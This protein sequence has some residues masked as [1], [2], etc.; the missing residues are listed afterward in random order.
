MSGSLIVTTKV[1]I[2]G[3]GDEINFSEIATMTVPVTWLGGYTIVKTATTKAIQLFDLQNDDGDN[4]L[5]DMDEMYGLYI[6]AEVGIIYVLVDATGVVTFDEDQNGIP[7]NVADF[8]LNVGEACWI[9]INPLG[10]IGLKIDAN[11]V[12]A[13]FSWVIVAKA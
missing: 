8:V 13:A 11:I 7:G 6:K 10:N 2:T 5:M 9:P 1:D 3:L 4:L 12:T